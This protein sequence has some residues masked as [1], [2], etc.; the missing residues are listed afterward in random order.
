MEL[1][2]NR[3]LSLISISFSKLRVVQC[4]SF[5]SK[6]P[7]NFPCCLA[8]FLLSL[9]WFGSL[10]IACHT[11]NIFL[12]FAHVPKPQFVCHTLIWGEHDNYFLLKLK[13]VHLTFLHVCSF[14]LTKNNSWSGLFF[15]WFF[16]WTCCFVLCSSWKTYVENCEAYILNSGFCSK[17]KF[18]EVYL[19]ASC[20]LVFAKNCFW[21]LPK[22]WF[23]VIKNGKYE[24]EFHVPSCISCETPTQIGRILA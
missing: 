2:I 5:C 9:H 18:T 4:S 7:L 15:C 21:K 19:C 13:F 1:G 23:E 11:K 17:T 8:I 10:K 12:N 16:Y 20:K 22:L 3:F 24:R 14:N 6:N